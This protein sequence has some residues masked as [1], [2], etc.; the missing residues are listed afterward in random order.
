M[1]NNQWKSR[2]RAWIINGLKLG[3]KP[4]SPLTPREM[5]TWLSRCQEIKDGIYK[6]NE[7]RDLILELRETIKSTRMRLAESS[8]VR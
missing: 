2:S 7:Y 1:R 3:R 6:L 5:L 4:V 8:E